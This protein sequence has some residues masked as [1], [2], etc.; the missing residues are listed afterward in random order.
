MGR[1]DKRLKNDL[2]DQRRHQYV[3]GSKS[4]FSPERQALRPVLMRHFFFYTLIEHLI[5]VDL[6]VA[7]VKR[8]PSVWPGARF[9]LGPSKPF[10]C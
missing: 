10:T 6:Y 5:H 8:V 3:A 2:W 7:H 1:R 9:D 4:I